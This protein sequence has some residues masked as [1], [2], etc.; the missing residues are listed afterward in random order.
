MGAL[1][2]GLIVTGLLA[3]RHCACHLVAHRLRTP[4]R[5][6]DKAF[7]STSLFWCGVVGWR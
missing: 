1:Y 2:R 5:V 3:R 7:T 4:L 6:G